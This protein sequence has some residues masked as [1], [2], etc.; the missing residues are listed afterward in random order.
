MLKKQHFLLLTSLFDHFSYS[1][2]LNLK[3][4]CNF[5]STITYVKQNI[6]TDN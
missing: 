6:I 2:C 4:K 1:F 5:A 3:K